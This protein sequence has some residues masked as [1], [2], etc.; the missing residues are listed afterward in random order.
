LVLAGLFV[1]HALLSGRWASA[2]WNLA[3]PHSCSAPSGSHM[4]ADLA[5][6]R[7]G[8]SKIPLTTQIPARLRRP[9]RPLE[10]AWQR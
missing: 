4:R 2:H 3:S 8:P 10:P 1:V 6:T 7:H 5:H 9:S